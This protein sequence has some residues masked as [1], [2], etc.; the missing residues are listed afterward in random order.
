MDEYAEFLYNKRP[1]YRR[2]E[3]GPNQR[4]NSFFKKK[5]FQEKFPLFL[6]KIFFQKKF[7]LKNLLFLFSKIFFS[8]K[9]FP[10]ISKKFSV[11][12]IEL[13]LYCFCRKFIETAPAAGNFKMQVLQ[14]VHDGSGVW[15]DGSLS[16]RWGQ[17]F[18]FTFSSFF[19]FRFNQSLCFGQSPCV[20]FAYLYF[21]LQPPDFASG[22]VK[23]DQKFFL[24]CF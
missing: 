7:Y 11:L 6:K 3:T 4:K 13:V 17:A 21:F 10:F 2:I 20:E 15:F 23:I 1:H 19:S 5:F 8:N 24:K 22:E 14:M 12:F 18:K 16:S 9:N